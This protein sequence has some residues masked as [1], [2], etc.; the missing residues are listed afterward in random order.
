MNILAI[1]TS[2]RVGSIA[3]LRDG[4]LIAE[5]SNE[6]VRG[7]GRYLLREVAK[8]L[9]AA[10][11]ALD[12]IDVFV[13]NIGPGSF[14]GV[15]I[16]LSSARGLAWSLNKTI[17]GADGLMALAYSI[18]NQAQVWIS[19]V[20]DA[21]KGE[22]YTALYRQ[23]ETGLHLVIDAVAT[24]VPSWLE[25][26]RDETNGGSVSF[27]GDGV[28]LLPSGLEAYHSSIKASDL[29]RVALLDKTVTGDWRAAL[30]RYVRAAEAE[31][32]FGMAPSH[33]P[34]AN[35]VRAD[36]HRQSK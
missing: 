3:I 27:I 11:M 26:V 21:R 9:D 34:M 13:A 20:L 10:S 33:S 36:G 15:R 23:D 28:G 16:G 6:P 22:I 19:P 32:K 8:V 2:S 4:Q 35:V 12:S 7:H 31:V 18:R 25:R 1:E 29:A 14:T 30:P 24:T 17:V 5:E